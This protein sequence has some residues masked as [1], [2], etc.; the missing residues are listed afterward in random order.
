MFL[1]D[2]VHDRGIPFVLYSKFEPCVDIYNLVIHLILV[3]KFFKWL[4]NLLLM[5]LTCCFY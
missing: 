1:L 2:A 3:A 5:S 4:K